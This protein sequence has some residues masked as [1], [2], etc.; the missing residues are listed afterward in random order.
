[1]LARAR[2]RTYGTCVVRVCVPYVHRTHINTHTHTHTNAHFA[3]R[4]AWRPAII[5]T[6]P[7]DSRSSYPRP[8]RTLMHPT[9]PRPVR[10][11]E[12]SSSPAVTMVIDLRRRRSP[13]MTLESTLLLVSFRSI[14]LLPP[15]FILLPLPPFILL[16]LPPFILLTLPP[17][18]LL[19]LPPSRNSVRTATSPDQRT[20]AGDQLFVVLR[21]DRKDTA[22]V[23]GKRNVRVITRAE[24]N[25]NISEN[26]EKIEKIPCRNDRLRR[27]CVFENQ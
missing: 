3:K 4:P 9:R 11:R 13:Y 22:A 24:T 18:I 6:Y 14:I 25:I 1:M 2:P 19:T 17:F 8:L 16:P 26:C 12:R 27:L 21:R 23:D 10:G 20:G 5:S 7:R 15:Q